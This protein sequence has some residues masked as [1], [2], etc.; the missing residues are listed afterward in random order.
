[1]LRVEEVAEMLS[2]SPQTVVRMSKDGRM[3]EPIRIGSNNRWLVG[4]V[5]EAIE[6]LKE[7]E[8]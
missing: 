2:C 1:M 5:M 4:D 6:K 3:P 7:R 8:E